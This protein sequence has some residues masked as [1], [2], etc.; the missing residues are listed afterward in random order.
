MRLNAFDTL[1]LALTDVFSDMVVSFIVFILWDTKE[2]ELSASLLAIGNL[3]IAAVVVAQNYMVII[4]YLILTSKNVLKGVGFDAPKR[5]LL[6]YS[7][8]E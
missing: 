6:E 7:I 8:E 4:T 2:G 1:L 3:S 5:T